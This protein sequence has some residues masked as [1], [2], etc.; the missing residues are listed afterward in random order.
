MHFAGAKE[1]QMTRC[2][3]LA[4]FFTVLM[5]SSAA[6]HAGVSDTVGFVHGLAHPFGGLD[7]VLAMVAVGFLAASLGGP[8]L[9]LIPGGFLLA[10]ARRQPSGHLGR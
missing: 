6:A 9:L 8:K 4:T 10:M 7:H 3:I 5:V 2:A 1:R